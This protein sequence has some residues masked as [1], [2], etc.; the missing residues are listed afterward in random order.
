MQPE[1]I[2]TI[3]SRRGSGPLKSWTAA[4][5]TQGFRTK[6]ITR[7]GAVQHRL[8][9]SGAIACVWVQVCRA[10]RPGRCCAA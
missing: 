10:N 8:R 7:S 9:R 4:H 5:V 2:L 1:R 3:V 6:L